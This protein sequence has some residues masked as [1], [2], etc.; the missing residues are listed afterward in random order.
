MIYQA[1]V[2]VLLVVFAINLILNLRAIRRPDRNSK[3]SEPAP[4][5]SVLI[6]A[7]NEEENIETCLKSLQKQDYSNFEVL[8]LDDNSTD[9][10]AELVERMAAKDDRIRLIRGK[11]LP[12]GWAGKPFA[13][14]QL[15][16]K[17]GGSWLLFVDA[18]TTHA[19]HMLRS[20]LALALELKPSLLSG[21]PRQLAE[22]LPEKIGMPVLYFVIM[23]WMPL[24]WLQRSKEPRPSLAVGQF[25]LFSKEDYWRIGGHK[26]VGSRILEDV[27]LGVETVRHGGHHI[28][29]DLSS[30]V[31]TRMYQGVREMW[32]GLVRSIYAIVAISPAALFGLL[33]A[34][35]VFYLA[36]FYWLWNAYFSMA[37]PTDWR[38]IVIFQVAMIIFMRWLVD[39]RFKEPFISAFV[40]PV[41]F[42]FLI[43]AVM[44]AGWRLVIGKSVRWKD[45]LYRELGYETKPDADAATRKS[46]LGQHR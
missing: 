33:I 4:L 1:I 20:T 19:P 30:V 31:S 11:P 10:T 40:H 22:S 41:G 42:S 29:I 37:A 16:E 38:Y 24:W 14:Y 23:S 2:A 5:V 9:R 46:D 35:F 28:A 44:Y 15:A 6:P 43:L 8:V 36:P 7:R 45:R 39:N 26:A 3:I 32:E 18:D 13:C 25:L 34:G 12:E 27:W 21:F 17:A